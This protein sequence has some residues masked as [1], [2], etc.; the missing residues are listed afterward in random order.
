M[1][2]QLDPKTTALVLIDLQQAIVSR[3]TQPHPAMEVVKRSAQLAD[4]F[5]KAGAMVV[6]VRVDIANFVTLPVDSPTRPPGSPTPP[7]EASQ[8]VPEAGMTTG[9]VLITKHHWGAFEGTDL[10]SQ[11]TNRGIKTIAIGGIATNMGVESTA[12]SAAGLG[13]AVVFVEDAITTMAADM[14]QFAVEKIFP[15]LGRV[16]TASQIELITT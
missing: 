16:R 15:R 13:F 4:K 2:V 10:Q 12:R 14:H 7:P 1:N 9:D 11:L 3:Q 8:L 5:R 6:Y